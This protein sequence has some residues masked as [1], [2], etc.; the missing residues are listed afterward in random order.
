VTRQ[1]HAGPASSEGMALFGGRWA[2][3]AQ[4]RSRERG[5][6]PRIM[7][8]EA[9]QDLYGHEGTETMVVGHVGPRLA[10]GRLLGDPRVQGRK[11][12]INRQLRALLNAFD[13]YANIGDLLRAA[14]PSRLIPV[15]MN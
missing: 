7:M 10:C 8:R 9:K 14:K 3:L 4:T 15:R 2:F 6:G 1:S 5:S 11:S 13:P 12:T